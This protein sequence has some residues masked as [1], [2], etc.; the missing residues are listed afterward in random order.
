MVT[1]P[2]VFL[3]PFIAFRKMLDAQKRIVGAI[4]LQDMRTRFGRSHLSYLIAILWPL[5]HLT[6]MLAGYVF[7]NKIAPVGEDPMTFAGTGVLPYILC[8]YPS[9]Q[10]A[11]S[12][13]QNR[14][15]LSIPVIFPLQIMIARFIVELITA[16]IICILF[17]AVLYLLDYNFMPHDLATASAAVAS[18]IYFGIGFGF[19]GV[20]IVV[21]LG[22][23]SVLVIIF[24]MLAIY[25]AS[26]VYLPPWLLSDEML[27][28]EYYNPFFNCVAWLRSAYYV[29]YDSI[30]INKSMVFWSGTV[31][32]LLG[33]LG[34]RFFRGKF[35]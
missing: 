31:L 30:P 12:V 1:Q 26:A 21:M 6:F 27:T 34:E 5:S 3:T 15:L 18:T 20:S 13:M 9:R 25:L 35:V 33:L 17:Y 23:Y 8:L 4:M 7:M 22:P 24:F 19:F 29:S 10:V 2:T 14:Q 16:F 32:L 28:Y 11:L